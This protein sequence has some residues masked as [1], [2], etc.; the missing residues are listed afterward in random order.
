VI[1][2]LKFFVYSI[3]ICTVIFSFVSIPTSYAQT[4][5]ITKSDF[6]D[7]VIFD[8]KWSFGHEWKPTSLTTIDTP[9]GSLYIRSAHQGDFI[10]ILVDSAFDIKPV[11]GS[12]RATVCFD[13]NVNK[14]AVT[15]SNDYCFVGIVGQNSTSILQGGSPLAATDYFKNIAS[16]PG[17]IGIGG[18]SGQYDI[19]GFTPHPSFEFKIPKDLL[20]RLDSYG[21]FVQF[22]DASANKFYS[23]PQAQ[24]GTYYSNI[25]SPDKWGEIVSPDHT[26]PESPFPVLVLVLAFFIVIYFN[27]NI[28]GHFKNN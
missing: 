18:I 14:T 10:Y 3:L 22:Y 24:D 20:G 9:S 11:T 1:Y 23:W 17:F 27:R 2:F 4:I 13:S 8:G 25:P 12:D 5:L 19:Y 21:F 16:P 15:N 28:S 6:M 26:M 7:K